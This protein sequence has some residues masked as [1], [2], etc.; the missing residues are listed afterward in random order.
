MNSFN[1]EE[2]ETP[3]SLFDRFNREF[4][5]TWDLCATHENKKCELYFTKVQDALQ[6]TWKPLE[7]AAWMCPP[8]NNELVVERW[9]RK[10]Y[11][12]SQWK[13][14]PIVCLL[15]SNT[16]TEHFHNF[17]LGKAEIRF[18]KASEYEGQLPGAML[19]AIFL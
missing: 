12:E 9:A 15:P 14:A 2:W 10:A 3:Q 16:G 11:D 13:T 5:F 8:I 7:G 18:L 1:V 17:L 6:R 4:K 19:V